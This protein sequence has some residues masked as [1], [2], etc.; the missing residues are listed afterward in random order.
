M[1][2]DDDGLALVGLAGLLV[3]GGRDDAGQA[4][5]YRSVSNS[6]CILLVRSSYEVG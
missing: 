3:G 2:Y 1:P 6:V 5:G 4:D